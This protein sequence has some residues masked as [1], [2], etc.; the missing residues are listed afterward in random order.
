MHS[1]RTPEDVC[2]TSFPRNQ[3][4]AKN[5]PKIPEAT[6]WQDWEGIPFSYVWEAASNLL[7][8]EVSYS[9][10]SSANMT[11]L[12]NGQIPKRLRPSKHEPNEHSLIHVHGR[13]E[14]YPAKDTNGIC[15]DPRKC[16]VHLKQSAYM[17]QK[18]N[19]SPT[20]IVF[21]KRQILQH[22]FYNATSN[23]YTCIVLIP[24]PYACKHAHERTGLLTEANG[25]RSRRRTRMYTKIRKPKKITTCLTCKNQDVWGEYGE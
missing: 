16:Q 21:A 5:E 18:Q 12:S 19:D 4:G 3:Q 6:A 10:H 7:S 9:W 22:D 17:L 14:N 24:P 2:D 23:S 25:T 8:N 11:W 15:L 20:T 13:K 1:K